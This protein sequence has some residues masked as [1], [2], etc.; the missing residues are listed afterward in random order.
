[1][2]LRFQTASAHCIFV[3]A[4]LV[5]MVGLLP[6]L[7]LATPL[8]LMDMQTGQ[9]LY[10][11]DAGRPW[12]PASLTK[13]MTA[14]VTFNAIE[15][16]RFNLD[17]HVTVSARALREPPSKMGLPVDTAMTL[18]VA[19]NFLL[20]KSANDI[21]VA[22]AETVSGSV[23]AFVVEM[24]QMASAIGM[25]ASNFS[26]PHGLHN[27]AQTVSARDLAILTLTIRQNFPQ[28]DSIFK[29]AEVRLGRARLE[30]NNNLLTDFTGTDGMK[31][32]FVCS[33]GLNIV[34]TV[35]RGGKRLLAVVLG[36]SS[37]RE[38]SERAAQMI[39]GALR[40]ELRGQGKTV[41]QIVNQTDV[42]PIDMRPNLCGANARA[43]VDQ[44]MVEF[45][46][47]LEGQASFLTD[48][49]APR[50]YVAAT[51][52]RLRDVTLPRPRPATAPILRQSIVSIPTVG[53]TNTLVDANSQI[54]FPR[55]RPSD[56]ILNQ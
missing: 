51:L 53:V 22:I 38:R 31:T 37:G 13:L 34:A 29:T 17:S 2:I 10:E 36:A 43:Y 21:A 32:G 54:P 12:H 40:G 33:A 46:F 56:L 49:I 18:E 24:N 15:N 42:R 39:T 6:K 35:N 8:L 50:V 28:Y 4:L 16:G 30:S 3:L 45:P 44:Q 11:E 20:V 25:T 1:M 27:S 47:G 14:L 19:L 55:P 26:N 41:T 48:N 9:V 7:A 52:G 23:D 5:S